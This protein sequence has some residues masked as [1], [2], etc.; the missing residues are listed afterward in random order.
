MPK[1]KLILV[2]SNDKD[3]PTGFTIVG[4]AERHQW[5]ISDEDIK[6]G[7]VDVE[8]PHPNNLSVA[9]L[10]LKAIMTLQ[11]KQRNVYA[12][13]QRAVNRLQERIQS[14]QQLTYVE[15][16]FDTYPEENV[17]STEEEIIEH[18]YELYP[19]GDVLD[20]EDQEDND[21]SWVSSNDNEDSY[22]SEKD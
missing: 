6:L 22:T 3:S 17:M 18:A 16:A 2:A 14:L 7:E 10:R 4:I 11:E 12:E 13:A 15:P 1:Q 8:V 20:S 21:P 19:E 9:D 5:Y